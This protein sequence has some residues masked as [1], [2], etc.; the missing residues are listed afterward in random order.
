[1]VMVRVMVRVSVS[2]SVRVACLAEVCAVVMH[3]GDFA[4][5]VE[6][7][8]DL[9]GVVRARVRVCDVYAYA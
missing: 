8:G 9:W 5:G 2:V 4:V 6:A 7:T 1:M 3:S